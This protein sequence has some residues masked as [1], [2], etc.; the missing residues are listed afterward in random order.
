MTTWTVSPDTKTSHMGASF[1]YMPT[2]LTHMPTG[3][4]ELQVSYTTTTP[5]DVPYSRP[6]GA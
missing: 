2:A 4:Q 6:L 1:T 5:S 3:Q